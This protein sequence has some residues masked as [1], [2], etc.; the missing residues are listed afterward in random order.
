LK[1]VKNLKLATDNQASLIV[2]PTKPVELEY[3]KLKT[4]S[5]SF[6]AVVTASHFYLLVFGGE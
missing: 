3:Q 4:N 5:A 6:F 1:G 2:G